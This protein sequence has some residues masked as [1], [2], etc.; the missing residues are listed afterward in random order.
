VLYVDRHKLALYCKIVS[1]ANFQY[2]TSCTIYFKQLLIDT[3]YCINLQCCL[4]PIKN[5]VH[6]QILF[7]IDRLKIALIHKAQNFKG[8]LQDVPFPG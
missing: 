8:H 3:I 7:S 2:F 6:Y 4:Q 1:T 5:I